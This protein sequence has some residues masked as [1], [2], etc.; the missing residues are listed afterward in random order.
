MPTAIVFVPLASGNFGYFTWFGF[1]VSGGFPFDVNVKYTND[2]DTGALNNN[3]NTRERCV[4]KSDTKFT[5][6]N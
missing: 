4:M 3:N 5:T 2:D 1:L 6:I